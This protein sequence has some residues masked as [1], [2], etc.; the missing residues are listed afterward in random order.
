MASVRRPSIHVTSGRSPISLFLDIADLGAAAGAAP[1][2]NEAA[3]EAD[4]IPADLIGQSSWSE[5][6]MQLRTSEHVMVR[7]AD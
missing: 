1:V 6:S 2:A 4:G 7:A 5:P 3:A